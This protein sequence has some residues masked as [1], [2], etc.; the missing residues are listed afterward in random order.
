ML[1]GMSVGCSLSGNSIGEIGFIIGS[2]ILD[3]MFDTVKKQSKNAY[4]Y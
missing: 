1:V 4:E 2:C 3:K